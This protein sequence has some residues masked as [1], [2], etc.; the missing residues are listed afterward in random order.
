MTK[1]F[2]DGLAALRMDATNL[3]AVFSNELFRIKQSCNRESSFIENFFCHII[4][5]LSEQ[6]EKILSKLRRQASGFERDISSNMEKVET[7]DRSWR[8]PSARW[9]A[10]STRSSW[11]SR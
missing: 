10:S 7:A 1:E 6:K 11:A 8:K 2:V 3:K 5:Q 4:E 9:R